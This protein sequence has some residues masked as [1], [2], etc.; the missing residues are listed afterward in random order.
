[1]E[2]DELEA[3]YRAY[4][5][6]VW[7]RCFAVLRNEAAAR[8]VTQDVF[9]RCLRHHR[10]LR[11]GRELLAWLYR[12][13]TNLC[14]NELRD[15]KVQFR[16][17]ETAASDTAEPS[18][19]PDAVSRVLTAQLTA[20]L[21]ARSRLVAYAVLVDGLTH[22]EAAEVAG[23]SERTVRNCLARV[24]DHGRRKLGISPQEETG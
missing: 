4:A 17:A 10:H 21:D 16:D 8:D 20:G 23:V 6:A 7:R 13:A 11:P 12:V 18:A 5:P 3:T 1:M 22:A 14:L 2:E 15:R 9:I 19:E 24:L